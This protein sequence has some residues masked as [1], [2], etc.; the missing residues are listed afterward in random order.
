LLGNGDGTF[1]AGTSIA[2]NFFPSGSPLL[3]GDFN[4]D[5]IPDLAVGA[6]S[7]IAVL[8]GNGDGTFQ[9]PRI[10]NL[11]ISP[12]SL[13]V[14]DFNSDGNPDL[15]AGGSGSTPGTIVVLLGNGNGTFQ[16]AKS[17]ATATSISALATGDFNGDGKPDLVT[18]NPNTDSVSV[19]LGNGDGTFSQQRDIP[20]GRNP[21][22]VAVGDMN[23]DGFTDIVAANSNSGNVSI[24]LG[25]GLGGFQAAF[26]FAVA[27]NPSSLTLGDFNNDGRL[28]VA[29]TSAGTNTVSVLLNAGSAF[30]A[31]EVEPLA[32]IRTLPA[33]TF[34]VGSNPGGLVAGDFNGDLLL[35]LVTVDRGSNSLSVLINNTRIA[36]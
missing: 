27:P 15:V 13:A 18:A 17:F 16:A 7:S 25:D 11:N 35:D 5:G 29:V 21:I 31:S 22:A 20:V 33:A 1:R 24:L 36:P 2:L 10:L 32:L 34:G 3:V 30:M 23:G 9:A 6:S 26:N 4:N 8:L 12:S 28:D 19:F 14:A